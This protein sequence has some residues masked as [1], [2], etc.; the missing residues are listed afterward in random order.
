MLDFGGAVRQEFL[1]GRAALQD[2]VNIR[3]LAVDFF[4]SLLHTV[5]GW[6]ERTLAEI[7]G[8]GTSPR[9]ARTSVGSTSWLGYR[10]R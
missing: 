2:Q 3:A 4:V 6:A 9:T 10:Y 8:W 5:D 1:E 7:E